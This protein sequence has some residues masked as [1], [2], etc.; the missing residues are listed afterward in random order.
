VAPQQN[1]SVLAD[2]STLITV[3]RDSLFFFLALFYLMGFTYFISYNTYFGA[4]ISFRDIS[5]LEFFA[6]MYNV[7]Y[8]HWLF[9]LL[10]LFGLFIAIIIVPILLR[11]DGASA[12]IGPEGQRS[13]FEQ[14]R[15]GGGAL[16]VGIAMVLLFCNL[17]TAWNAGS[18]DAFTS[19]AINI[20]FKSSAAKRSYPPKL[21]AALT[22]NT[23]LGAYLLAEGTGYFHVAV[24]QLPD[25]SPIAVVLVKKDDVE[26]ISHA[27]N[28]RQPSFVW[29]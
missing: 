8:H 7:F 18:V 16:V 10:Q 25:F 4:D 27:G 21:L 28:L 20:G 24:V 2:F 5:P 12:G 11:R 1:D 3:V 15:S 19:P 23:K 6:F 26:W 22:G 17:A 14:V 9:E 29:H 13:F